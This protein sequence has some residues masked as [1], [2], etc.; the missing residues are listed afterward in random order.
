MSCT[1]SMHGEW[2]SGGVQCVTEKKTIESE[3]IAMSKVKGIPGRHGRFFHRATVNCSVSTA[4]DVFTDHEGYTE[5]TASQA[6]LIKEGEKDRNGLGAIREISIQEMEDSM[7]R[8]VVNYWVPERVFGYHIMQPADH[9]P[10]HHQGV[11]RFY[12]R[13]ENR[14]EWVYSMR[15]II[16]PKMMEMYGEGL[17]DELLKGFGEFMRDLESEC[18][19]RGHDIAIPAFPPSVED[20]AIERGL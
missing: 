18:E 13:G 6:I 2:P 15:C 8:E 16:T 20:Q 1:Q 11:V 10:S 5:F 9:N 14:C 4:W 3:K 19:R 12:P 17:Y 7:V